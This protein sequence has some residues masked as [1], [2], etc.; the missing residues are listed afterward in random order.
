MW[1]EG[2]GCTGDIVKAS[3]LNNYAEP[4]AAHKSPGNS[5]V[6][7]TKVSAW[8]IVSAFATIAYGIL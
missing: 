6:A 7:T 8:A 1:D 5:S 4:A 2:T 3:N